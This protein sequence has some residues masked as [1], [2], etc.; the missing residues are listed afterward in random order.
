MW[1]KEVL[2]TLELG[3]QNLEPRAKKEIMTV[4]LL[5]KQISKHEA[6][7]LWFTLIIWVPFSFISW[8]FIER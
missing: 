5:F 2:I 8:M 4:F 6:S 7:F 3:G 1:L